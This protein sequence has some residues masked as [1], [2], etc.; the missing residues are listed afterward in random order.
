VGIKCDQH[1]LQHTVHVQKHEIENCVLVNNTLI[2]ST[3]RFRASS[4]GE[5]L[6]KKVVVVG[7]GWAGFGAA[8]ALAKLGFSTTLLDASP[9]PGG[10][11]TG[12]RTTLGRPVEAGI[13]GFWWQYHN[14]YHLVQELGIEWPFT[15]WTMSSFYSPQGI[16]VESPVFSALPRLPTPLGSFLYTSPY[17]R[18]LLK[19]IHSLIPTLVFP[20][21]IQGQ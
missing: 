9:N 14:I 21:C 6:E 2:F 13:K 19:R 3:H 5:K 10:L 20:L 15:E 18:S 11:S 8:H 4:V 16:Q 1:I 7:G 12:F 17:F